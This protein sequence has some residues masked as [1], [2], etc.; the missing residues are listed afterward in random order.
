MRAWSSNGQKYVANLSLSHALTTQPAVP[1]KIA[2]LVYAIFASLPFYLFF[3]AAQ[4]HNRPQGA[5]IVGMFLR[6][7][8][9][10]LLLTAVL[11]QLIAVIAL[12]AGGTR[13]RLKMFGVVVDKTELARVV[14]GLGAAVWGGAR[15]ARLAEREEAWHLRVV[16]QIGLSLVLVSLSKRVNLGLFLLMGVQCGVLWAVR[17]RVSVLAMAGLVVALQQASFFAFGGSN[18]LAT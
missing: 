15:A 18:S 7:L 16:Q 8:S 9:F 17:R 3:R 10:A 14:Y 13:L 2:F 11:L 1:A 6:A 4:P 12:H 5:T